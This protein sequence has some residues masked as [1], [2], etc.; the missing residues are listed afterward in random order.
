MRVCSGTGKEAVAARDKQCLGL[1]VLG[2]QLE[3]ASERGGSVCVT[4]GDGLPR[5]RGSK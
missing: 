1:R 4:V 3:V 2:E 5:H